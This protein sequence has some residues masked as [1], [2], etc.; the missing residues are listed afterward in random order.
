MTAAPVQLS[1][2]SEAR[3]FVYLL[4]AIFSHVYF[5]PC[6]RCLQDDWYCLNMLTMHYQLIVYILYDN[7]WLQTIAGSHNILVFVFFSAQGVW[8]SEH[9]FLLVCSEIQKDSC[10]MELSPL[11]SPRVCNPPSHHGVCCSQ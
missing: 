4:H 7:K 1:F 2:Y 10:V 8:D 6:K 3:L 11:C 5:P 9:V